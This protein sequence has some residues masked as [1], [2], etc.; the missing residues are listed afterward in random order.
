M[1][2][3]VKAPGEILRVL[4]V[5]RETFEPALASLVLELQ[6]CRG[7]VGGKNPPLHPEEG[8]RKEGQKPTRASLGS[9]LTGWAPL[10]K[11]V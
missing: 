1:S 3:G 10:I 11:M 6:K 4:V 2:F 8:I 7:D 9:R 5:V